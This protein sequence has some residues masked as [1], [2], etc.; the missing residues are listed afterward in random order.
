MNLATTPGLRQLYDCGAIGAIDLQLGQTLARLCQDSN[1][2]LLLAAALTSRAV[3]AGHVCLDLNVQPLLLD[4]SD[5]PIV[6]P[7]PS[8]AEWR[9]LLEGRSA[10]SDGSRATPLVLAPEGRLYL[11]RYADYERRLA[12]AVEQRLGV[13]S[14][15]DEPFLRQRI[16]H[17]FGGTPRLPLDQQQVAVFMALRQRLAVISGGPGT[18][19]T[20]TVAK[21]LLLLQEH[22]R[23]RGTSLKIQLLAPTGK[24]AQRLTESLEQGLASSDADAEVMASLPRTASTIHRAL[25]YSART[26]TRF[27]RNAE[28]P[29]AA[30]VVVVDEA[31]MVDLALMTKLMEAIAPKARLVLL[32]D[33]DQ[34]ASVEAGAIFGDIMG[35]QSPAYSRAFA[36]QAQRV[37]G[38]PARALPTFADQQRPAISDA[39]IHLEK[40]YRYSEDSGIGQAAAALRRCDVDQLLN[41]LSDTDEAQL[42]ATDE[43]NEREI[44]RALEQVVW[45][46]Y[47][48]YGREKDPQA[49]LALLDR[50][51][52]LSPHRR[53]PFGVAWLNA[54]VERVLS[55]RA[56]LRPS[57]RSYDGQ[58]IMVTENDYQL[59]LFNGDIGVVGPNE[60][61]TRLVAYFKASQGVRAVPL[62]RLPNHET[63]FAMTVHKSQGSEFDRVLLVLPHKASAIL[64]R[65][66]LYTAI[67]RAKRG[68]TI[69]GSKD[70]IRRGTTTGIHRASGLARRLWTPS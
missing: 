42:I 26:P 17:W 27:L 32:G 62:S 45:D 64:T 15:I 4:E 5:T 2:E 33:R 30:D 67:T 8:V 41:A 47:A 46:G 12:A 37:L 48:S 52:I 63:V 36:E 1:E 21:M 7:W 59:E 24:A 66:L 60:Q 13:G 54:L 53:G 58:P 10:V 14:S 22:A 57:G 70:V 25:G 29:I 65:E 16:E 40:S 9:P 38:E 11:K 18:G 20:T 34:L 50:F 56:G 3:Q 6:I 44:A 51:R 43:A 49:R 28:R 31:S 68:V 35:N 61:G 39:V 55:D 23:H 69:V 19:K